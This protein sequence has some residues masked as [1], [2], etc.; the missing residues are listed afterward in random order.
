MRYL[1][2]SP[3]APPRGCA[4]P[5][6]ARTPRLI[7][8]PCRPLK[9]ILARWAILP[10]IPIL[11]LGSPPRVILRLILAGRYHPPRRVS[12]GC[13]YSARAACLSRA[14]RFAAWFNDQSEVRRDL[15]WPYIC[16]IGRTR[17]GQP[18]S[19]AAYHRYARSGDWVHPAM[20]GRGRAFLYWAGR[21]YHATWGSLGHKLGLSLAY[22]APRPLRMA[23]WLLF[24]VPLFI[25]FAFTAAAFIRF[26]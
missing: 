13:R 21:L 23:A 3:R 18:D 4:R 25:G 7:P 8:I 11:I 14:D 26:I 1:I 5:A 24:A 22:S 20:D 16:L 10:P 15:L 2:G 6:T 17:N 12:R 9:P 19:I